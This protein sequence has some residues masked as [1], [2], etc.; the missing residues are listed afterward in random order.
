MT[1]PDVGDIA[2]VDLSDGRGTEQS[3]RRPALI[4]TSED[5]H[6]RS[7]R[8]VICPITTKLRG[9]P[10]SVLLPNGLQT[11]GEVLTDQVRTIDRTVRMFGIV[12]KAPA[13]VVRDVRIKLASLLGID[14]DVLN[15]DADNA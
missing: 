13:E 11:I 5:F 1:L 10:T 15:D 6:Q 9:W 2:W 8:A 4:L 3:G 7:H 12:E 14:L